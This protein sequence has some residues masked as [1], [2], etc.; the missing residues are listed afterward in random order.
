MSLPYQSTIEANM[1][2][3]ARH[4][5]EQRFLVGPQEVSLGLASLLH[6]NL[7]DREQV[8]S[9]LRMVFASNPSERRRF[10]ALF[11]EFWLGGYLKPDDE[12]R[13]SLNPPPQQNRIQSLSMLEWD[14]GADSNET[15]DTMGYSTHEVKAK[16]DTLVQKDDIEALSKL[17][18]RLAKHLATKPSR[19]FRASSKRG[20]LADLRRSIRSS[21]SRG[22]ELLEL[23]YKRRVLGKTRIVFVFDVSGSMMVYSHFLLQLAYAFVRQKHMGKAEVFGFSTELYRLTQHLNHG[24]VEEAI[25][26]ARNAMPGRSGG[27]KIG[28]SLTSLLE[29]YGRVLDPKTVLIINSDGWDTG[30]L[31]LLKRSMQKLHER[32]KY[33]IWLNPLAASPGYEPSA[34][35]MQTVLPYVDVFAASHNLE[36]LFALE[37]KLKRLSA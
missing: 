37:S 12:L 1:L 6:I 2:S 18:T 16:N 8:R 32:S 5:R 23:K 3:F 29:D 24:G 31:D 30:D 25:L 26:A 28:R 10:D 9:A 13:P 17:V 14:R 36:S 27:T 11:D 4:L 33:I 20:E 21:L 7:T 34:S 35:G 19:R 22:G 15:I